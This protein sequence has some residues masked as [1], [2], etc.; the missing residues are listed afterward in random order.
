[1]ALEFVERGGQAE[2]RRGALVR[3]RGAVEHVL[4]ER[5]RAGVVARAREQGRAQM[6][7][8]VPHLALRVGQRGDL[9]ERQRRQFGLSLFE[10]VGALVQG[11]AHRGDAPGCDPRGGRIRRRNGVGEHVERRRLL[12]ARG[13]D[14]GQR[15]RLL[16]RLCGP[17]RDAFQHRVL[18]GQVTADMADE[19]GL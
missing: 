2:R 10:T 7:D 11:G 9:I 6:P 17:V 1:M 18:A 12:T 5:G 14:V 16:G 8:I 4:P 19:R 15:Q 13:K 3:S